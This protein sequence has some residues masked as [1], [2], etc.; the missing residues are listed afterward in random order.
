MVLSADL[1]EVGLYISVNRVVTVL[2]CSPDTEC[3][4]LEQ[5][6]ILLHPFTL[7]GKVSFSPESSIGCHYGLSRP[8]RGP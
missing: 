1:P 5:Q 8:E 6:W 7:S 2:V 3:E 4:R